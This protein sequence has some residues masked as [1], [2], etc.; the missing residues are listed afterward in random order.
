MK[1]RN[2]FLNSLK[3]DTQEYKELHKMDEKSKAAFDAKKIREDWEK[4]G[5]CIQLS[6]EKEKEQNE[7]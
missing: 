2:Q 4:V 6:I 5:N 7:K 1:K 3:A